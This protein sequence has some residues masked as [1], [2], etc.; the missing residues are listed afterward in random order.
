MTVSKL[1]VLSRTFQNTNDM[2]AK[3]VQS[4]ATVVIEG[5]EDMVLLFKQ[6][7]WPVATAT[8]VIEY[9]GPV[10]QKMVQ[11]QQSKT[12]QEGPFTIYET[13]NNHADLFLKNLIEQGGEFNATVYAG[14]PDDFKMKHEI[15]K[16]ILVCDTPDRDWE[17]DTSPLMI[18][19]T[20]HYH[21]FGN[22]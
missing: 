16:A 6:F 13:V 20:L 7:P 9:F 15:K 14:R 19:G 21:W 2:G 3:A 12:K 22:Q 10:G 8:D 11:P 4:D 18:S 1:A 5:Y 17:N